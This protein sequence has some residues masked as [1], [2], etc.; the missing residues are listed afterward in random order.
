MDVVDAQLHIGPGMIDSTLEQMD[1]IGIRSVLIEEYWYWIRTTNPLHNHPGHEMANGAW[2]A[3]F[4]TAE[5]ASILHPDR[6]GFFVRVDR[7]DPDLECVM[8]VIAGSPHA[9]AFRFLAT[10]NREEAAAFIAGG[11][12]EPFELVQE[13]ELPVC[14]AIP[15]Y[16]EHL[17]QYATRFPD[18]QFVVDHWGF[19]MANNTSEQPEG[20]HRRA[21]GV[22]Y[23][24]V[25]LGLAEQPNVSIKIS[26][27]HSFFGAT[28]PGYEAVRPHLR[29]VIETFGA[30]RVLWSTDQT[31][32]HPSAS[33]S[34]LLHT[35]A[36]DPEL[37]A[38]EKELVLGANARRIFDWP[39]AAPPPGRA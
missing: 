36:D 18:V 31:V 13:L 4:P 35:V 2:R 38:E 8:R 17:A 37:S 21:M 30:D 1:A 19:A 5:T 24:D 32:T 9:R 20:D 34:D 16:V 39:V 29:R 11:Y 6:F 23:L 10:R 28:A 27:G 22:G 33:W 3:S 26:H 25:I 7:N 15:G 14:L 12:V